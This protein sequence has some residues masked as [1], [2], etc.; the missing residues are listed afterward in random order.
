MRNE[1]VN[2]NKFHWLDQHQNWLL[3]QEV[4]CG[5]IN[6]IFLLLS[7]RVFRD[8]LPSSAW[9]TQ[10]LLCA[11]LSFHNYFFVL[12]LIFKLK[13]L[14][15][16]ENNGVALF[17]CNYTIILLQK[18]QLFCAQKCEKIR[19]VPH[20]HFLAFF[21]SLSKRLKSHDKRPILGCI[22]FHSCKSLDAGKVLGP[23]L[24]S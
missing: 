13:S 3:N 17:L 14:E 7:N 21:L 19:F 15:I 5:E 16:D 12:L 11:K 6:N 9:C 23:F 20:L 1:K 2:F 10:K 22:G 18:C 24:V 4:W 8:F